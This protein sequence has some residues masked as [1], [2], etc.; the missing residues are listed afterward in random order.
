ML[1]EERAEL[2]QYTELDRRRRC[3]Q[4]TLYDKELAKAAAEMEKVRDRPPRVVY[5]APWQQ[6]LLLRGTPPS[7]VVKRKLSRH[8]ILPVP[9]LFRPPPVLTAV[10]STRHLS[11]PLPLRPAARARGRAAA[12]ERGP[13][14]SL[15]HS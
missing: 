5:S 7:R 12:R 4:Y 8:L 13:R 15:S 1:D 14:P 11:T 2:Q 6:M 9:A 3:L 10:P